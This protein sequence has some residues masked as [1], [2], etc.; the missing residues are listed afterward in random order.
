MLLS[1][2]LHDA[3]ASKTLTIGTAESCTGGGVAAAIVAVAGSSAYFKGGIVAYSNEVKAQLLGVSKQIISQ[4][5]AVC[6]AV[7]RQM[8]VGACERLQVDIAVSLTGIAGPG[9]GSADIP[10]GTIW[11]GYGS[12]DDIHT[13]CLSGDEGRSRNLE[14]ATAKALQ[15]LIDY[16]EARY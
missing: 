16:I 11:I 2:Q 1:R 6:E 7:A 8:V 3:L 15:V 13:L 4:Q 5:T 12:H 14:R 10:V 9:G